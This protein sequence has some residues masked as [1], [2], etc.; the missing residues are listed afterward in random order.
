MDATTTP[1]KDER[2]LG[3][4]AHLLGFAGWIFPLGNIIGPLILWQMKKDQSA[5]ITYHAKEALNFQI[6]V[7]V[8]AIVFIVLSF[9]LI[10]IPLLVALGIFDLVFILIA[11]IKANDGVSYRYPL[12]FRAIA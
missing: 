4:V 10:G 2:T 3:M 9:V 8:L 5:Y 11:A 12:C 6:T 1:T 7:S